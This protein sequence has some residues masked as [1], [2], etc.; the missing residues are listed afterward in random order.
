MNNQY[1]KLSHWLIQLNEQEFQNVI[2]EFLNSEDRSVLT[3]PVNR[4]SLIGD[5]Q[6][7]NKG[8]ELEDYL[9]KKYPDKFEEKLSDS[10]HVPFVN[11]VE[12][13]EIILSSYTSSYHLLDAPAGYGKT[14][15]LKKIE[16]ELQKTHLC[17]YFSINEDRQTLP[18]LIKA[19]FDNF[20]FGESPKNASPERLVADLGNFVKQERKKNTE[21]QG[22]VFLIDLEKSDKLSSSSL[23]KDLFEIFIPRMQ[24]SLGS[25]NFFLSSS[26]RFRVVIAGRYL[27]SLEE[28]KSTSL[29]FHIHKLSLFSY[30]I[31]L[32]LAQ[33]YFKGN[34][35]EDDIKTISSHIMSLSGGHPGYMAALLGK[36]KEG[37]PPPDEFLDAYKE[38]IREI[39][40][41]KIGHVFE[42]IDK[43]LRDIMKL[44]SPCR[45]FDY[46]FLR[47]FIEKGVIQADDAYDLADRLTNAYLI[48]RKDGFLQDDITRRLLAVRL[49][50]DDSKKFI[51]ICKAAKESYT[52]ALSNPKTTRPEIIVIEL[53]Y[54]EL[55]LAYCQQEQ[56]TEETFSE[57]VNENLNILIADRDVQ[58][59]IDNFVEALMDDWEFQFVLNYFQ[60]KDTYNDQPYQRLKQ[61]INE[62]R[63]SLSKAHKGD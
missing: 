32:H 50:Q 35:S 15:L 26:S 13:I 41:D 39:R 21:M 61:Q 48:V 37:C 18:K 63:Q 9:K 17:G 52:Y 28:V 36:Y 53:L 58:E 45:R 3:P 29:P 1:E 42:N 23:L 60:R 49:Y 2:N 8:S 12:K 56:N 51:E 22:I 25:D 6:T 24:R 27:T 44:L 55:Q 47:Q 33:I 5:I 20:N 34:I 16:Q 57:A 54:Q 62:F 7:W 43:E 59:M 4:G 30:R 19:M 40:D 46:L 31:L 38:D 10:S 14:A 11:Q